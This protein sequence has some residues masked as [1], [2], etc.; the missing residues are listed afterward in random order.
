MEDLLREM[1]LKRPD[2]FDGLD[3]LGEDESAQAARL[4]LISNSHM[5]FLPPASMSLPMARV[6]RDALRG[7]RGRLDYVS[8]SSMPI[9]PKA[10]NIIFEQGLKTTRRN[11]N[12][13]GLMLRGCAFPDEEAVSGLLLQPLEDF[14]SN[15][16]TSA[17]HHSLARGLQQNTTLKFLDVSLVFWTDRQLAAILNAIVGHPS[18]TKLDLEG[19]VVGPLSLRA[20]RKVLSSP[21][22]R[23]KA[24]DLSHLNHV[25]DIGQDSE[26]TALDKEGLMDA[27]D[28]SHSLEQV[29]L[30]HNNCCSY[31]DLCRIIRLLRR[32]AHICQLGIDDFLPD[33]TARMKTIG[34]RSTIRAL[35]HQNR[36]CSKFIWEASR[37]GSIPAVWPHC[38]GRVNRILRTHCQR[39]HALFPLVQAFFGVPG[40]IHS[41]NGNEEREE[42]ND[43]AALSSSTTTPIH[44]N[45]RQGQKRKR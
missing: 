41:N 43:A 34:L 27:L 28:Q 37:A 33:G 5:R 31:L 21:R 10:A 44:D 35:L 36:T 20:L 26:L 40:A 1:I 38:L 24:L 22:C 12:L 45:N 6:L 9:T 42:Y 19:S 16:T 29:M 11:P 4:E 25:R 3:L 39:A 13:G 32:H 2:A 17:A 30:N 18:L 7:N 8:L 23:V 14:D 15:T